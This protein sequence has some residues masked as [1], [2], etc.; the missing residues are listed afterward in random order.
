MR[1]LRSLRAI[2]LLLGALALA[3]CGEKDAPAPAPKA[4]HGPHDGTLAVLKDASGKAAGHVELK[5][6]DDK[7]DLELWIAKDEAMREPFLLPLD[8][9]IEVVFEDRDNRIVPLRVRNKERNEDEDDV[10]TVRDGRTHYFIFPGE[11]GADATWLMGEKF[12]AHVHVSF[13]AGAGAHRT[14]SFELR[15]H[16]QAGHGHE[17]D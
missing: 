3:A 9:E 11:T 10:A 16:G 12:H 7:G 8:T 13:G 2:P 4:A 14:A 1:H 17:H 5:L 15:P 6:H